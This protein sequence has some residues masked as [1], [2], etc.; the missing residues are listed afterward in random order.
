MIVGKHC[1]VTQMIEIS[2]NID[3]NFLTSLH[4]SA[5]YIAVFA[6]IDA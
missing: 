5:I 3:G 6:V 4:I 2:T 1:E